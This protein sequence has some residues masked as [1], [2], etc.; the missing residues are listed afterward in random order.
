MI[1][2]RIVVLSTAAVLLLVLLP[3][4]AENTKPFK[5]VLWGTGGIPLGAM[6]DGHPVGTGLCRGDSNFGKFECT[7]TGYTEM[8]VPVEDQ[9]RCPGGMKVP[10]KTI[11]NNHIVRFENGDVLW[12][13]PVDPQ[14]E[15]DASYVCLNAQGPPL[16]VM[17]WEIKGGSGRFQGA[18]GRATWRLTG[19]PVPLGSHT[20]WAVHPGPFEGYITM[21]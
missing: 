7:T 18:T 2:V 19:D 14:S 1:R 13:L 16:Q 5:M 17:S 21:Q 6:I 12:M 10:F 11:K 3:L 4:Y 15:P 20:M 9:A 8:D